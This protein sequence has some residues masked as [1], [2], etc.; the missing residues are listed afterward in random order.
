MRRAGENL[1]VLGQ[2][3]T[4]QREYKMIILVLAG[5]LVGVA[6]AQSRQYYIEESP[7]TWTE[8]QKFC[9]RDYTDLATI[10]D[11]ADV[12]A[13]NSLPLDY[14]ASS[15]KAWIGLHDDLLDGWRWSLTDSSLYADGEADYRNWHPDEP[16][17]LGGQGRCVAMSTQ[18]SY[19]GFWE[20]VDCS[21]PQHF[22]CYRSS[23][24]GSLSFVEVRQRLN[25]TE[26]RRFCRQTYLDLASIR[27]DTEN[28]IIS[29]FT[30]QA[31]VWI[32]L[33]REKV[34][35]DGS[36]SEFRHWASG[37]P[38][39]GLHQCVSACF[40]DS[41]RWSDENCSLSLPFVC[42]KT[43]TDLSSSAGASEEEEVL[44]SL[45]IFSSETEFFFAKNQNETS[46]T[47][48]WD[49]VGGNVSF[50]LRF[51]GREISITPPVG[52]EPVTH[53][54]WS[55]TPGTSYTF[56]L[57]SV[58]ENVTSSSIVLEAVTAPSNAE[59]F[60]ATHQNETSVT[61]QWDPVGGNVSFLLQF[62]GREISITAPVGEEPVTHTVWSLTPGTS[63]TFT[64]ISVFENVRSSGV[65][66]TV[67]PG[68]TQQ[69][70][71]FACVLE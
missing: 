25:W 51:N 47:L 59:N 42:Y 35:S 33:H 34:W 67:T 16:K 3:G 52:E 53:T 50:L 5:A 21:L 69:R 36:T 17:D 70:Q 18:M 64:L 62:D 49:P 20:A 43:T 9:R 15:G 71:T 57:I 48:Q 39:S 13:V 2:R 23:A 22:V 46:I 45:H 58:F 7:L 31:A 26:A 27:N 63:Y 14:S 37:Q 55:L 65:K 19:A 28:D 12:S 40:N 8:A 41:G 44:I 66:I 68:E 54:V 11:S 4:G 10:E 6:S 38:D 24:N 32:G 56:T 1:S 30:G 29:N 61:L 60:R